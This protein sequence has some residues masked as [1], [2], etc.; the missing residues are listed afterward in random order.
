M[1]KN[2]KEIPYGDSGKFMSLIN[3]YDDISDVIY[4]Y[5]RTTESSIVISELAMITKTM[6]HGIQKKT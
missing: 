6:Y 4:T 5:N 3:N 1:T 2:K